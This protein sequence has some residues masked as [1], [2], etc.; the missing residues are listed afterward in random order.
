MKPLVVHPAWCWAY[1]FRGLPV[2]VHRNGFANVSLKYSTNDNIRSHIS[3]NEEKLLR[4][5]RMFFWSSDSTG[6]TDFLAITDSFHFKTSNESKYS[7]LE[8][9]TQDQIGRTTRNENSSNLIFEVSFKAKSGG[10]GFRKAFCP[11]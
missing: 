5:N 2:N 7:N 9:S 3:S 8:K 1:F 11:V 10:S 6:D 4:F